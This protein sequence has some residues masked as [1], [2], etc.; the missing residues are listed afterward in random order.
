MTPPNTPTASLL[1]V[2]SGQ[3]WLVPVVA[4]LVVVHQL[5]DRQDHQEIDDQG[6][7]QK[8]DNR[9]DQV[10]HLERHPTNRKR[11]A[12]GMTEPQI[13]TLRVENVIQP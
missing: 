4:G 10:T 8:R 11:Q 7:Q 2:H 3:S 5:V 12:A 13:E 1:L 9:I 6:N